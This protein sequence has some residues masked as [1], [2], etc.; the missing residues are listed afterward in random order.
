MLEELV[1]QTFFELEA[2]SVT[3]C[4]GQCHRPAKNRIGAISLAVS[5]GRDATKRA[6]EVLE[7]GS[8]CDPRT[9]SSPKVRTRP[10][11]EIH[12]RH[13]AVMNQGDPG[14]DRYFESLGQLRT[15]SQAC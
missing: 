13:L 1:R 15:S 12:N 3:S 9:L 7:I 10:I 5:R 4:R 8:P 14:V 2:R 6:G 11:A